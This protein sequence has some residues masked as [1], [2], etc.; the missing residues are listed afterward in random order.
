MMKVCILGSSD[1]FTFDYLMLAIRLGV[2]DAKVNR[3]VTDRQFRTINLSQKYGVDCVTIKQDLSMPRED[4]SDRLMEQVPADT[5]LIVI[6][7]RRLIGGR[8]L[9]YYENQI[10]N[11]HP[12][13]LP[14]YPGY[15]WT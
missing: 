10:L 11:T 2:I 3:I 13:L 6:S 4:Y 8:I 5:D 9:D 14:A 12:S 15:S 1:G 7:L